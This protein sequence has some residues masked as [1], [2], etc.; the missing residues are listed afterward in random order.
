[1]G[2][3]TTYCEGKQLTQMI[4]M[5]QQGAVAFTD[6]THPIQQAG[7][8][9]K[10][11]QYVQAFNGVIIQCPTDASLAA[12]GQMHEGVLST[13]LGLSGLPAIAEEAMLQR[14]IALCAETTSKLHVTGISTA[15][16]I[17][18]IRTAKAAGIPITCSVS[19][20]HLLLTQAE[21]DNYNTNA[22]VNPPLRTQA[23][24]T[25]LQQALVGDIIDCVAS[26][27]LPQHTDVKQCEFA[28]AA[29]GMSTIQHTFNAVATVPNITALQ[30]VNLLQHNV[31][32]AFNLTTQ[33]IAIGNKC[34]HVIFRLDAH[35]TVTEA[36]MASKSNHSAFLDKQL[37]GKIIAT[38][39]NQ[40]TYI[41]Q[42]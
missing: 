18:I 19:P 14:D 4:E 34:N 39:H 8:L 21:V 26:H 30:I 24:V 10:A 16:S 23:D 36:S 40:H 3:V 42:L 17:N 5:Q 12:Q 41:N 37:N 9:F 11:M 32:K 31:A 33:P 27:H 1:M 35:T 29:F 7:I 38:L 2:A 25:A 13:Q 28:N 22:K 20:Y 6:G 15:V